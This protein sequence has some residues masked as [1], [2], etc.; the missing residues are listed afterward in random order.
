MISM[1]FRPAAM[2]REG[3]M[4]AHAIGIAVCV[5]PMTGS[6][7]V[8]QCEAQKCK[9]GA[10]SRFF[11]RQDSGKRV[12]GGWIGKGKRFDHRKS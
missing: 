11:G 10:T 2:L 4:Y 12:I 8:L 9:K 3:S 7:S 5:N 1:D 6:H